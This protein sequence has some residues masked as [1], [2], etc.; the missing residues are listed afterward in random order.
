MSEIVDCIAW[1]VQ[2]TCWTFYVFCEFVFLRILDLFGLLFNILACM[3]IIRLPCMIRQFVVMKSM[4]DW[5]L[6]GFIQCLIF[7]MDIPIIFMA[8]GAL[9]FSFG[10][11]YFPMKRE[12][13]EKRIK[14]DYRYKNSRGIYFGGFKL[15]KLVVRYF[16]KHLTGLLCIP[17]LLLTLLSWRS[18]ILARKLRLHNYF[19]WKWRKVILLQ[20][21]QLFVD[22]PCV[23]V[24][25]FVVISWRLP[26]YIRDVKEVRQDHSW[27][28]WRFVAFVH[29]ALLFVDLF[30]FLLFILTMITWRFPLLIKELRSNSC[31]SQ[32]DVRAV[33]VKQFLLIFV[34]IPC[35][36]CFLLVLITVWRLPRFIKNLEKD[37]WEIRINCVY[38]ALMM[39]VDFV[40]F[41]IFGIVLLTLWRLYPLIRDIRKYKKLRSAARPPD[42]AETSHHHSELNVVSRRSSWKIR[43]AICKHF[44]FLLIDIPA[45]LLSSLLFITMF[46][47]PSFVAKLIQSGDFYSE[48]AMIVFMEVGKLLVDIVFLFLFILLMILRPFA[49]WVHLL[50]DEEHMQYRHICFHIKGISHMVKEMR[51]KLSI[52]LDEEFSLCLKDRVD[53]IQTRTR[54]S[55]ICE[56]YLKP[57]ELLRV[58]VLEND[59]YPDLAHLITTVMW[60]ERRRPYKV[61]RRYACELSYVER[62]VPSVHD[63][64]IANHQQEMTEYEEKLI[65]VYNELLQYSPPKVPLWQTR[66]GLF[67][68]SRRETQKVLLGLPGGN[69]IYFLLILLNWLFVYRGPRLIIDL[70]H[71]WCNRRSIIL[72]SLKEYLLDAVTFLRIFIV[73]IFVYRAPALILDIT[74]DIFHKHS[75]TAVR[76][77]AKRYPLMIIDDITGIIST[78]LHW[79]T[80]RFLFTAVLF[81]IL[82]PVDVLLTVFKLS[83]DKCTAYLLSA[84]LF[85]V[86]MGFPFAFAFY[87]GEQLLNDGFGII[88]SYIIGGYGL[89]FVV[90][91]VVLISILLKNRGTKFSVA[92]EP[93]DYVRLN[94]ENVHVV[95]FEIVEVLQLI[96]LVFSLNELPMAGS[97]VLN[98]F[99][100]YLLFNFASFEVKLSLTVAGF[101]VWFVVCGAPII[102]ENILEEL[103]E[104]KCASNP[105]W[106]L[107]MSLFSNTLFLSII[108]G[109]CGLAACDYSDNACN[110][111]WTNTN[112]TCYTSSLPDNPNTMCWVG[113]HRGFALFGLWGLFWYTTTAIIYGTEYG[114][115]DSAN[116]DI[117]FSPVYN[118]VMNF[119]KAVMIGAVVLISAN[120]YTTLVILLVLSLVA[121]LFT[122]FFKRLVGYVFCNS[123]V[124]SYFRVASFVILGF[125]VVS[126]LVAK[127]LGDSESYIPL[128]VFLVSSFGTLLVVCI[129]SMFRKKQTATEKLR[130]QFRKYILTLEKRL[131]K[132][133]LMSASWKDK[134]MQWRRL[135]R[136]VYQ[137]QKYDRNV[138]PEVWERLGQS[139]TTADYAAPPAPPPDFA[140]R[141]AGHLSSNTRT[142]ET[143]EDYTAPPTIPPPDFV[144]QHPSPSSAQPKD[145]S[146]SESSLGETS[147]NAG[148]LIDNENAATKRVTTANTALPPTEVISVM[149]EHYAGK[150]D[151]NDF[152][153]SRARNLLRLQDRDDDDA[154]EVASMRHLQC[155]G[156]NILLFLERF[157]RFSAFSFSFVSQIPLWRQAVSGSDWTGLF[158]CVQI[159][160][161]A[162]TGEFNKPTEL[163]ISLGNPNMLPGILGPD[164]D[165]E[166]PPS[167]TPEPRDPESIKCISDAERERALRDV[168]RLCPEEPTWLAVFEKVLPTIPIIRKW[169]VQEDS[170]DFELILRRPCQATVVDVGPKGIKLAKGAVIVLPK[171]LKGVL[172]DNRLVFEKRCEP[173]GKKGP[174]SVAVSEI[175]ILKVGEKIYL[176]SNGKKI[177]VEKAIDSL[178]SVKWN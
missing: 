2:K 31:T 160:D 149:P 71:R 129:A 113:K 133:D 35:I 141:H 145:P 119:L 36:F 110:N 57:W 163:D 59:A 144:A 117:K 24:A 30:C 171:R 157:I 154:S 63:E 124:V 51:E 178:K 134:R 175:E 49:S 156:K 128:A 56:P 21:L 100:N 112:S 127:R 159:L 146:L 67:T 52:A 40:C 75:W 94:W 32:R 106:R 103:N 161:K 116:V 155:N 169:S 26:F 18:V 121:V 91:L 115:V 53:I 22:I 90:L 34:D 167:F 176:S 70:Y 170:N 150:Y 50:E 135:V 174:V 7:I 47:L 83:F 23:F 102:F 64:N 39:M 97:E 125:S 98:K 42:T 48:F 15:R 66:C 38:Q 131:T 122:I 96:A 73:L 109:L 74:I 5:R 12:I 162:L 153:E 9:I 143:D 19:E 37:E 8:F 33:V 16:F 126:A 1:V 20:F 86:Y 89:S 111:N 25:F 14:C 132:E 165:N 72:R 65:S 4:S 173:V 92:P 105:G 45:I 29:F 166:M 152:L 138:S 77:T 120:H 62:P 28:K 6:A 78:I 80:V 99:S 44:I 101:L 108:E 17:L 10:L 76:V 151:L 88:I 58:K 85:L 140:A 142:S 93:Y 61:I 95:V 55:Q 60:Y 137:A 54:L 136:N 139:E 3:T 11:V 148:I 84:L 164:P 104:G 27:S 82:I 68:R 81:G 123:V 114:E 147:F 46:R 107:L 130:K 69:I 158:H 79:R 168:Q 118:T 177:N 13:E 172:F 43:K 41:L 87:F